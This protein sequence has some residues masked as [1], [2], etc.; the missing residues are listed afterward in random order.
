MQNE[1]NSANKKIGVP[2]RLFIKGIQV[3]TFMDY[4]A[5]LNEAVADTKTFFAQEGYQ[6]VE[7]EIDQLPR[8]PGTD[9]IPTLVVRCSA[10]KK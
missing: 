2:T 9:P 5:D 10:G 8:W 3:G 6:E 7:V 4:Y 1:K